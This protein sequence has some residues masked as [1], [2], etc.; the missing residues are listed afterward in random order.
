[1]SPDVNNVAQIL[2]GTRKNI[3]SSKYG[4][5]LAKLKDHAR[6]IDSALEGKTWLIGERVTLA[7]IACGV[8]LT[9][10]F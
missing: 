6:N 3:D 4:N 2:Y 10:A 9:P 8:V 7:D 5:D 1:M